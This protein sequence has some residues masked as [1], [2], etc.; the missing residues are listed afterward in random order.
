MSERQ[1]PAPLMRAPSVDEHTRHSEVTEC[2]CGHTGRIEKKGTGL[3]LW[4]RILKSFECAFHTSYRVS[5][6]VH[7]H[8]H[9]ESSHGR[10]H[11]VV[12]LCIK[13]GQCLRVR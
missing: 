13:L 7:V 2:S 11:S 4:C 8:T 6:A 9:F 12:I 3:S 5:S 10:C 1:R